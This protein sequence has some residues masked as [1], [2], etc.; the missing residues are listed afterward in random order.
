[1]QTA[2]L[3]GRWSPHLPLENIKILRRDRP[4]AQCTLSTHIN[5][6]CCLYLL[7]Y[8]T[9]C[10]FFAVF[11]AYST[12]LLFI[13]TA[14]CSTPIMLIIEDIRD[15]EMLERLGTSHVRNSFIYYFMFCWCTHIESM[16]ECAAS[17]AASRV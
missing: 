1:M 4:K 5:L 12:I 13:T 15:V 2:S 9:P 3:W 17:L 10:T 14:L 8:W 7:L 16:H 11:T 6:H